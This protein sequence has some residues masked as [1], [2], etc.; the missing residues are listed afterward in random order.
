MSFDFRFPIAGM[1]AA[2]Y[3][4]RKISPDALDALARSIETFGMAKPVIVSQ[5]GL[6]IAGHQR[7]K[8]LAQLGHA[9]APAFV[10]D[11]HLSP[12][13][14]RSFNTLHHGTDVEPE[15]ADEVRVPG[16]DDLGY[17]W[18]APR[19]IRG[20]ER[21]P[22]AVVRSEI[23]KLVA[24]YGAWGCCVV[25]QSG[26]VIG[27][28]QYA[29]AC[30]V[31]GE[32]C[33]VFR[34]PDELTDQAIE[35]FRR[36]Y[37]EFDFAGIDNPPW[38]QSFSQP[39][40]LRR[41]CGTGSA[42]VRSDAY[43]GYVIPALRQ[44]PGLRVLDFGCGQGDYVDVL[45]GQGYNVW[46]IEFFA[47]HRD[48]IDPGAVHLMCAEL[49][50]EL[51]QGGL[52]DIVVC[53]FVVNSCV[54]HEAIADV[55]RCCNGLAR[56]GGTI[57]VSGRAIEG[58]EAAMGSRT[59]VSIARMIESMDSTGHAK[60]PERGAWSG[61]TWHREADAKRLV[62]QYL[63]DRYTYIRH[64]GNKWLARAHKTVVLPAPEVEAALM[65]EFDLAWP[66]GRSVDRA[67]EAVAAW[68]QA[69][70]GSPQA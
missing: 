27:S 1:Q 28:R 46:G 45:R 43:E 40:R 19:Q 49:F 33:L 47:R 3:N 7:A 53:D 69:Q 41:Q 11:V 70:S 6:I 16:A 62:E 39:R 14:E 35:C 48:K 66:D 64:G 59:K 37:G 57:L 63:S 54:D 21:T 29:L 60:K 17:Q 30:S 20:S 42:D 24:N 50:A 56:A 51:E 2:G 65:R 38:M 15:I 55:L 8:A 36:P 10:L 12:H 5:A 26:L 13:A 32:R 34:I 44:D 68:R 61:Q 58:I 23:C 25:N 22:G 67:N 18:V 9:E 31:M 52:F 4:P